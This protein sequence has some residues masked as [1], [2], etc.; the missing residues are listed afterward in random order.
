M[1]GRD[2]ARRSPSRPKRTSAGSCSV[3]PA[4]S[5]PSPTTF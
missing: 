4:T 5:A 1:G 3:L 2:S